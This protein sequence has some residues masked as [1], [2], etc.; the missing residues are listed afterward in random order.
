[1][2]IIEREKAIYLRNKGFSYNDIASK[3]CV[4]KGSLS[5]WLIG[6]SFVP[7]EKV[8]HRRYLSR[9]KAGQMLHNRKISRT[10]S[11]SNSAY[12]EI[13][14]L[15]KNELKLIGIIAYWTEGS[16][17][18]DSLVKFTNSDPEF[19][20]FSL[21]W[22]REVCLVPEDKIKIH[23]RIHDDLNKKK[24][25]QFWSQITGIPLSRFYKTTFKKSNSLGKRKNRLQY[26]IASVTVCDTNLF[27]KIR[28][29]IKG[30]I[31]QL[32]SL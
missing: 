26:G 28:G 10:E 13:D 22:L 1:M 30:V 25:E 24:I 31:N 17:T 20:R 14:S 12:K 11:I 21:K 18:R 4:S 15:T 7:S 5:R 29:W 6:V 16:K 23:L 9:I 3:L 8:I 27:Y 32:F 19:I 2:K